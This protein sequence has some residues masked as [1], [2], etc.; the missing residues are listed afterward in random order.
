MFVRMWMT[1]KIITVPP[2]TPILDAREVMRK[3]NIR[4]LPVVNKKGKLVGIVTQGDIQEAGPSDATTL[5]IWELNYL[6]ARTTVEQIMT[7]SNDLLTV[8]P[9]DPIEQAALLM[10]KHRISG[11][12][13]LDDKEK[14]VGIITES[15]VFE[16]LLE[17][18]GM[19]K[20]GTRL[21]VEL[22]NEPG[23]LSEALDVVKQHEVNVFSVVTCEECRTTRD[24]GVVVL[25]LAS[26]DW[27]PIVKDLKDKEIK[28]LDAR[29]ME[30]TK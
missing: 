22:E 24:R 18:M 7:K 6:L 16:V 21:T 11:L 4:R 14:L 5:S 10:R 17:L 28:V 15:D 27:R 9:D 25:R 8:S 30:E 1:T 2:E 29:D 23:A 26:N 13:V 12:P 20:G 3:N 19:R